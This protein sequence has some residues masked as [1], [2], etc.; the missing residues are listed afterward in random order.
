MENGGARTIKMVGFF[1]FLM[2]FEFIFLICK[3]NLYAITHGEPWKDLL[4]MIGLAAILLPLHHWVEHKVL[5]ILTTQNR[6]TTAGAS[7]RK[8]FFKE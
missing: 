4:F 7:L 1:A 5:H 8:K 3:K 6:L 2:F